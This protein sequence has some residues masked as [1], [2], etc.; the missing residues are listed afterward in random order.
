MLWA[1]GWDR[2]APA[3]WV[4]GS[5]QLPAVRAVGLQQ[6]AHGEAEG[7]GRA[8]G[9]GPQHTEAGRQEADGRGWLTGR[10]IQGLAL[11]G[12]GEWCHHPKGMWGTRR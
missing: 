3:P 2:P 1:V 11:G 6:Q 8:L 12:N 4:P 5:L 10:G 9:V 7:E